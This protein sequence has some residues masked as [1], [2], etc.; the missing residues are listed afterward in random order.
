M[1]I[2]EVESLL[3]AHA[4]ALNRQRGEAFESDLSHYRPVKASAVEPLFRAA[5]L[6]RATLRRV[7]PRPDFV[8]D[9]KARLVAAHAKRPQNGGA[10]WL[11]AGVG[12]LL[13]ILSLVV[14]GVRRGQAARRV[15]VPQR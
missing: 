15:A 6:A 1:K 7:Q 8:A 9:L 14:I 5:A 11:V 4:E 3:V 10:V 13:S 12:G 2:R